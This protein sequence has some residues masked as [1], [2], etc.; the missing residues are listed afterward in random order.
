MNKTIQSMKFLGLDMINKAN[1]GHPGIVLGA[2]GTVYNLYTKHMNANPEKPEWFNRDRF[3]LSAGH[4]SALL[5]A[6]LHLAGYKLT[7]DDLKDFRQLNSRTPGHPEYGEAPGV[8]STTGP[9]GQGMSMAVGN[10]L[11]ESYLSAKFNSKEHKLV[12]HYTYALCGDGDM[13]EGITLESMAIAGRFQ[14]SKLIVLFDSN[15]VQLDGP[16]DNAHSDDIQQKVKSMNWDYHLIDKYHDYEALNEAI[17]KAKKSDKPS[18]IEV[19]TIIGEGASSAGTS[20][21][22]GKPIG[23]EETNKMREEAG[24]KKDLFEVYDEAY[25]EFKDTFIKR[26]QTKYSEWIKTLSKVKEKDIETYKQF[27]DVVDN[28]L[29][30]DFNEIFNVAKVGMKEATRATMGKLI[31]I[32]SEHI[33][34][35]VGGSA[36]L[37]ASTK[38][39]GINGDFDVNHRIGRNINFGVREHAMAGIVNG[40]TLH[41]LK[42]FSGGFLIFS[43][44]MKPAM[45]IAALMDV[46]SIYIFTHDSVA[47][48]EDGPTHE[49]I[50]QLTM[51][52]AM[53]N[54][55][56]F[57]P[58]NAFEVEHALRYA[59]E[60]KTTPSII[61]LTRQAI[62]TKNKV[63]YDS[64]KTGAY[65]VKD[66]EKFEAVFIATG[67]EL[68]LALTI[69]EKLAKQHNIHIRVVSM[70]S[71]ELFLAQPKEIQDR[72]VPN[73]C[74]NIIAIEMGSS[75]SWYRFANKVYGIDEFGRSGKGEEV[76]D[77]FGF[78]AEKIIEDYLKD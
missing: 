22:H 36:D 50:E 2:A 41:N 55:N 51:Y 62:A 10:A 12:D 37:T 52:R 16:V 72:I 33:P 35:M 77:F 59:L 47:V 6:T 49:P 15:D 61:A 76:T 54:I 7:K 48:G 56:V 21:S 1:S 28:K 38:A 67:S 64:F 25:E 23:V 65:I 78:T 63:D 75:L 13:Q 39:K 9:L 31:E 34:H 11:A 60:S 3:I 44:Y 57:R 19:K 27:M 18:F 42:A 40:M 66:Y 30:I 68:E 5:Y 14:L 73:K 58:G 20:E 4:G 70:P 32:A 26:G 46:P 45:R 24:Y 8:D 43:D 71:Q 29:N 53:P 17:E 74:K 69:Q